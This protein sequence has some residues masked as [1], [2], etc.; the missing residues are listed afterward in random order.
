MHRQR[1]LVD[2]LET[3]KNWTG[4]VVPSITIDKGE[5]PRHFLV[6]ELSYVQFKNGKFVEFTPPWAN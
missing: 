6:K 4:T 5:A 1:R 2:A 3:I